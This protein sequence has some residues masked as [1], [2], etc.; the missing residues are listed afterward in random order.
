MSNQKITK[1]DK[2]SDF[3]EKNLKKSKKTQLSGE[4]DKRKS[5]TIR[6]KKPYRVDV[7]LPNGKRVTKTFHRKYDADKF[8]AELLIKKRNIEE[9]GTDVDRDMKFK[10]FVKYWFNVEVVGRKAPK[11][12]KSY[13]SN[14][15]NYILPFIEDIK[16]RHLS[17]NHARII[18]NSVMKTGRSNRTINKVIMQ[19]KT[20]IN[21]AVK[22]G[23]IVKSPFRGYPELKVQPKPINYWSKDEI[24]IF[25]KKNEDDF[26]IDLYKVALNTGMRL[27]ELCGLCWDRVNFE[28]QTITVA[29]TLTREGLKNTTKTNRA[30]HLP[31]NTTT[32]LVL[33]KRFKT[34]NTKFVFHMKDFRP[35]TYDHFTQR[36]FKLAQMKA[37]LSKR[38]RFHDLRH[39]YA[40][41]FVMNGG[42]IYVLQK[43][44]GH[45]DISTTMIYAHLDEKFLRQA[46]E[47]I[48][49]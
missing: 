48:N 36:E 22:H 25:L 16:L 1:S 27:G 11:T 7:R 34:K 47:I 40:S 13:E 39:T 12:Q 15:K 38:I 3:F 10:D 24:N 26:F 20:I 6:K 31:M 44:L 5:K 29:R 14:L 18:E 21:D 19:L 33:E 9:T 35:I 8:K 45:T 46:T 42:D 4:S 41:H 17:Y 43:L 23:F 32:R 2:N 49:F 30:R 37:G 28:S